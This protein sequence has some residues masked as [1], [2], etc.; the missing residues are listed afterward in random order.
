MK[1]A[2][3]FTYSG[4]GRIVISRSAPRGLAAGYKLYRPLNP[5]P[6]FNSVSRVEYIRRYNDILATLDPQKVW[7]E[8]HVLAGGAE[9]VLLCFERPPFT[10]KNFCHRRMVAEW[11]RQE[12]GMEVPELAK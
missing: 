7:D 2:S 10:E 12:L 5:G 8:L 11:L 1:T 4:P 3:F 6:W 9:P